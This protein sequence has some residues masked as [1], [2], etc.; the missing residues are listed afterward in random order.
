[1]KK[2]LFAALV[3]VSTANAEVI[4]CPERYPTKDVT[5]SDNPSG[6][7][8][9]AR[10]QPTRL[11]NA[12]MVSGELYAEQQFVPEITKVKGG[13]DIGYNF[14]NEGRWLVCL[15][16]GG[17]RMAGSIDWW[18]RLNPKITECVLKLR[19]TKVPH[20]ESAWAATA[21]CK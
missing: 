18:D 14:P 16:G 12:Y 5:V 6:R 4:K 17:E 20:G 8:G 11:S 19:E 10:L 3:L 7:K 9:V 1:M 13:L 2:L 21:T 15:Y